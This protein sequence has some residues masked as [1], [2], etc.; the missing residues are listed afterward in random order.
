MQKAENLQGHF[1]GGNEVEKKETYFVMFYF[2]KSMN[3]NVIKTSKAK[4]I[5]LFKQ[6][7]A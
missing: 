1:T 6:Y 3:Y 4:P 5:T 2:R 7:E